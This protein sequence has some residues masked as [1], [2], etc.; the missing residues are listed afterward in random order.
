MWLLP[1]C[2][3]TNWLK[4]PVT[5]LV[6]PVSS[7]SG[8]PLL[9]L[10]SPWSVLFY[11]TV[12]CSLPWDRLLSMSCPYVQCLSITPSYARATSMSMLTDLHNSFLLQSNCKVIHSVSSS[13][14]PYVTTLCCKTRPSIFLWRHFSWRLFRA[15]DYENVLI[16]VSLGTQ[17][18]VPSYCLNALIRLP[19]PI[20]WKYLISNFPPS[21]AELFRLPPHRSGTHYQT[22]SFRHQQSNTAVVPAPI[23]NFFYFNDPSFIS[24]VIVVSH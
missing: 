16:N 4:I 22:Q 11:I 6:L 1:D 9:P 19:A 7:T 5:Q 8:S 18:A 20:A 21:A 2:V 10:T 17:R 13:T 24:T 3:N 14:S 23:E 15:R 12:L